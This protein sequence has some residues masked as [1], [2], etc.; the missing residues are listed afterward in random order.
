MLN[1]KISKKK[2]RAL[3]IAGAGM[4]L[5]MVGVGGTVDAAAVTY[6]PNAQATTESAL[7]VGSGA[8][9]TDDKTIAVGSNA[10]ATMWDAT[11]VGANA[12]ATV[13]QT[14]AVG[15]ESRATAMATTAMGDK[16][17]ANQKN[18]SAIGMSAAA[19]GENATALGTY[20]EASGKDTTALGVDATATAEFATAIGGNSQVKGYSSTGI[21]ADVVVSGNDST[22]LGVTAKATAAE[23]SVFGFNAKATQE[24]GTAIGSEAGA[25]G[26]SATAIGAS[27]KAEAENA[28]AIGYSA[29]A[30]QAASMAIGSK[31]SATGVNSLSL[32]TKA[33]STAKNAIAIGTNSVANEADTVSFGKDVDATTGKGGMT[34]RITH[35][36]A[37]VNNTDAVNVAQLEKAIQDINWEFIHTKNASSNDM[38]ENTS[39][40][41]GNNNTINS[42][43]DS[44]IIGGDSN[45]LDSVTASV[46]L[47]GQNN[48]VQKPTSKENM[49]TQGGSS[50]IVGGKFNLIK[51]DNSAIIG[52]TDST[53]L[54]TTSGVF[55][56]E[57]GTIKASTKNAAI[58]GG[59]GNTID[60]H[61]SNG[62]IMGGQDNLVK[63]YDNG[64]IGGGY[65]NTTKAE[66]AAIIGG[67]DNLASEKSAVVIGG[68][69]NTAEGVS[70]IAIG[71]EDNLA[72]GNTTVTIG[73]KNNYTDAYD[74]IVIGGE[75]QENYGEHS[76]IIG[77]NNGQIKGQS[78]NSAIVGGLENNMDSVNAAVILGGNGNIIESF[79]DE[80][81]VD[82]GDGYGHYEKKQIHSDYSAIIGGHE[83]KVSQAADAAVIAG[84]GNTAS[85]ESAVVVGGSDN[86]ASGYHSVAIGGINTKATNENAVAMNGGKATGKNTLAIGSAAEASNENSIALHGKALG[87]NT[88]AVGADS[89]A[90]K[91][92]AIALGDAAQATSEN[93]VAIGAL[94]VA[95]EENTVSVGSDEN[96]RRITHVREGVKDSDAVNVSQLKE[97]MA[98]AGTNT[99]VTTSDGNIKLVETKK[100]E[101]TT[102]Y[103]IALSRNL[104]ADSYSVGGKTYVSADGINANDQKV[105]NV[106]NGEIAK[107]STDAVNGG[108]LHDVKT[109][110]NDSITN[111]TNNFNKSLEN[112]ADVDLGNINVGGRKVIEEIAKGVDTT[113]KV[114]TKDKNL[115]VTATKEDGKTTNYDV[116]LNPNLNV[117]SLSIDGKTY[118]SSFGL[119]AN[120]QFIEHVRKGINDTDAVNVAQLKD[121]IQQAEANNVQ[122]FNSTK[123]EVHLEGEGGTR[124]ANVRD[125]VADQDAVN[126]RQLDT[127]KTDVKNLTNE[128]KNKADIDLKNIN[129]DGKKV[130]K[131]L[132][133]SVDDTAEV[134]N[135]DGNLTVSSTKKGNVTTYD[136]NLAKDIKADSYSV[137]D[138]TYITNVGINANGNKITNVAKGDVTKDSTDAVNG[139][140]LYEVQQQITN[141]I[142]S[143]MT[144][145]ADIDLK[146]IN[147]DGKTVIKDLAESVEKTTTVK[148]GDNNVQVS[149]DVVGNNTEYTVKLGDNIEA[150]T[151]GVNGKTYISETGLN[152][153]GNKV[154]N[155]ADGSVEEGSTDAVNG[156]QLH[157]VKTD[158]EGNI[159]NVTNKF[160]N[161][162]KNKA[163]IDL[164]NINEGGKKV[165]TDLA[166]SVE[167]TSE[168]TNTDGNLTVTAK[169]DGNNTVYDVNLAKN[170]NA[171]SY[172]V[173]DKTYITNI[174][175]NANNQKIT[176][177]AGGD[178]AEGSTDAVNGD[179]LYNVQK[180]I[181]N[182][183]DV[184]MS[185]KADVDLKNI[186]ESGKEVIKELADSV[187]DT[188]EV[189]TK[190]KNLKVTSEKNGNVTTYDVAMARD[191]D[192]DSLSV[193]GKTYIT[194]VGINA[195]NQKITNVADG[196]ITEGS[197]DAVNGG[198][199]HEVQKNITN[200]FD[201]KLDGKANINLDNITKEGETVI[202]NIAK[203][204][205][206]NSEVTTKDKNL[207]VTSEQKGNT[208]VYDVAMA[209]D[210]DVDSLSVGGKTY[211]TNVGIN[212]NGQ[213]V[214]NV[215]DGEVSKDS[216]D[217]VNGSQLYDVQQNI[218]N[219]FDTKL[220]GKANINLDNIT[221]DG[222]KVI[223]DLAKTV[224]TT[225]VVK[226]GD[227]NILVAPEMDGNVTTYTVKLADTIRANAF[228]IGDNI[229]VSANGFNANN[230]RIINVANGVDDTDAV[231]V[232]Q[233]K[234]AIQNSKNPLVVEYDSEKKDTVTL[235]GEHGT[236]MDNVKDGKVSKDSK[237]AVNGSQLYDTNQKVEQNAEDIKNIQ[238]N[239]TNNTNNI[240]QNA[241]DIKNLQE[242]D[243]LNVKYTDGSQTKITLGGEGGTTIKN[244]KAAT[245]DDEA[246]NYKQLNDA[247]AE[248][249]AKSNDK[250]AVHYTDDSHKKAVLDGEGGTSLT[251]VS[252][253]EVSK[254]SQDAVNGSQLYDEQEARKKAD[255]DLDNRIG[256]LNGDTYNV[257]KAGDNV[258]QNLVNLDKAI[259]ANTNNGLVKDNGKEITIAGNSETKVINVAGKGGETRVI[260]GVQTNPADG[261]SAANVDFVNSQTKKSQEYANGIGAQAAAM[262][263]LHPLDWDKKDKV[264]VAA[265]VGAYK[266]EVAGAVGAFYR[267]DRKTMVSFQ[268]AFGH[269]D[270]MF[271]VGVSK[272]FGN[273][274][275]E[276]I[277]DDQL[278]EK[279]EELTNENKALQVQ[280][281]DFAKQLA[282][283]SD[284]YNALLEKVNKLLPSDEK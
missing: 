52:S 61:S 204:V 231:N 177:V 63:G 283:I 221:K 76:A 73:G 30:T 10:K 199:L 15:A 183:I 262:S 33:S 142:G 180:N 98:N 127:V 112:K 269:N 154:V 109:E 228:G 70:S 94:S 148:A 232:G 12:Q 192:V 185:K 89:V 149:E 5:T 124:I 39:I 80:V 58:M 131:D 248:V 53:V 25:T 226:A 266:S 159:T 100:D 191:L 27:S 2:K 133:D 132:A 272:K 40:L 235:K 267:P 219:N 135:K 41:D 24:F 224:D 252:D 44:A 253:G 3:A 88:V 93:A 202:E 187:D 37:G 84:H 273:Q 31:S 190:D 141:N 271:G 259:A 129:E 174:G 263:S 182:K 123:T 179:Q 181:N 150:K 35:V 126:V 188:A 83:N 113:A 77:G 43:T 119:D 198:Q 32:G 210:L 161:E 206:T 92:N 171:D 103:D 85:G 87:K 276:E 213:K 234:Q 256:T 223:T 121:S 66:N 128:V 242:A 74:S 251:G 178:V 254:D 105:T 160:E 175:I 108:Q 237:E 71:G 115:F 257:I 110:L 147:E 162:L 218:T 209:R 34:R 130:I 201:G 214:T 46:I 227:T 146:N 8:T 164:K 86:E 56:A 170:I 104:D 91:E 143:D 69:K 125:G 6:G 101:K 173:G 75:K 50:A 16:A 166:E 241:E 96:N 65:H 23:T 72:T 78:S 275:T 216:K 264:S 230:T 194:N 95:D 167:K 193:G 157:K 117:H 38:N 279:L 21:G 196:E 189:T 238:T 203:S 20:A 258:S 158:I 140:Q 284:A 168:V 138:K 59:K 270:N 81:Y 14:L 184:D 163:D 225:A 4:S 99:E 106:A 265:S 107:G 280:N 11:A 18:A 26:E 249:Q 247:I 42:N 156:G 68:Q 1:K 240:N 62:V 207:K 47:G 102:S 277:D 144:N 197:H 13:D 120:G 282:K 51:G 212:A 137:G 111:V 145:K 97:A 243:K 67:N 17:E 7:A 151:F 48:T 268:G 169:R 246:V 57:N 22:A 134:T 55:A 176:N 278:Q 9:A 244:V 217:A 45:T 186:T 255:K 200:N 136:V 64:F 250:N 205:D 236:T 229:F 261:T 118:V 211:I 28:T 245:E 152:A 215:A 60:P 29:K 54:G 82:E 239:V 233:L 114:T 281:N 172:S 195:N 222:E 36:T 139:S 90:S 260:T 19:T 79:D 220:D 122:Y 155:V 49:D 208:T 274:E 116:A 153:N 165:I